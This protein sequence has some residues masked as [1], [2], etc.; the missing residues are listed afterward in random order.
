MILRSVGRKAAEVA[1]PVSK[2]KLLGITA[3]SC[4]ASRGLH[5]ETLGCI[6]TTW[7]FAGRYTS[8]GE[9]ECPNDF[10]ADN[11]DNFCAQLKRD[12]TRAAVM[13]VKPS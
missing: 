9:V 12:A 13:N 2:A 3:A 11:R 5:A 8:Q 10:N 4:L 7:D 6:V 1:H